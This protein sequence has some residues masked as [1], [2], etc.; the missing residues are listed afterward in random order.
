MT[1]WREK[2]K[3]AEPTF[4]AFFPPNYDPCVHFLVRSLSLETLSKLISLMGRDL[5]CLIDDFFIHL[6]VFVVY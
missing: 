6:L 4:E 5:S 2:S 1:W 3:L